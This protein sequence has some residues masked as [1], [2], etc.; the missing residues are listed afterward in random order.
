MLLAFS[1]ASSAVRN[2]RIESTGPK[3]SSRAIRIDGPT[4]VKNEA[5]KNAPRAGSAALCTCKVAPSAI[6]LSTSSWI[7]ASCSR[8][9]IAP[10]SVFLSSGSP[11][12]KV[13]MRSRNIAT[14]WSWIDSW[15][16]SREPAQQT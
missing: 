2:V 12:R 15:T 9:L 6:P 5:G 7:R 14:T 10:M 1:I 3:I 11:M 16:N 4:P 13:S 8:E